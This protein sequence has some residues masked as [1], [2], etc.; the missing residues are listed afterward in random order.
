MD[1]TSTKLGLEPM[2]DGLQT[3][4]MARRGTNEIPTIGSVDNQFVDCE[5]HHFPNRDARWSGLKNDV[6]EGTCLSSSSSCSLMLPVL[7]SCPRPIM[8]NYLMTC[9]SPT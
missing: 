5:T 4:R 1:G 7:R 2:R 8:Q 6:M 3:A 9:K